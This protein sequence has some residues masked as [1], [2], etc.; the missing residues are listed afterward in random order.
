M[1]SL[2]ISRKFLR[3]GSAA[4]KRNRHNFWNDPVFKISF[5]FEET[6]TSSEEILGCAELGYKFLHGFGNCCPSISAPMDTRGG[7]LY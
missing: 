4:L 7:E 2:E 3:G 5:E 1:E 6:N